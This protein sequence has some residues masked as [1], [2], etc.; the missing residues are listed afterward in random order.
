MRTVGR[1]IV[2]EADGG[3]VVP[4]YRPTD[5]E[6]ERWLQ[7]ARAN[8]APAKRV[9]VV[10]IAGGVCDIFAPIPG[11]GSGLPILRRRFGAEMVSR[12]PP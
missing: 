9:A 6:M 4:V 12:A 5:P 1:K 7:H 11:V 8:R 10:E 2:R 3:F